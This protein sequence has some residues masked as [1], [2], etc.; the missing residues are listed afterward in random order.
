[1]FAPNISRCSLNKGEIW[2]S[3]FIRL[4]ITI[5]VKTRRRRKEI[6]TLVAIPDNN[7]KMK[8][9]GDFF[10]RFYA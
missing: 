7:G 1:M 3:A 2:L 5:V 9:D 10:N 6:M 4:E 8:S